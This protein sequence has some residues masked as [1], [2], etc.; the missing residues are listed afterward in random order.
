MKDTEG[1][2][3]VFL[4]EN[5]EYMIEILGDIRVY[6]YKWFDKPD[7]NDPLQCNGE[8]RFIRNIGEYDILSYGNPEEG[9]IHSVPYPVL[10]TPD[11]TKLM[12]YNKGTLTFE[13]IDV[14]TGSKIWDVPSHVI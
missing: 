11:F 7:S 6:L 13:I 1:K 14:I 10:V 12:Y 4:S 9:E 2:E 8:Y 5:H 3:R